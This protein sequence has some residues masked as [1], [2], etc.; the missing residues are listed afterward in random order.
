MP[1]GTQT[2]DYDA[3][4]QQARGS[5][6]APPIDYDALADSARKATIAPPPPPKPGFIERLGQ[7]TGIPT[8]K[9]EVEAQGKD[10]PGA[11]TEA[12]LGPAVPAARGI[13]DWAKRAAGNIGEG[14]QE[15]YE[16]ARNI[17]EG[18]PIGQNLG[19]AG[20]GIVH[21][22]V[23]SLPFIGEGIERAGQDV[24]NKNY[25]GAAGGLTGVV[26]QVALP[27]AIERGGRTISAVRSRVA[28]GGITPP[29]SIPPGLSTEAEANAQIPIARRGVSNI[30]RAASPAGSNVDFVERAYTAAPDLAEI[31]RRTPLKG[32]VDAQGNPIKGGIVRPD[33]RI[34]QFVD[35]G[36]SYL[37]DLWQKEREP[38]IERNR[39]APTATRDSL[40]YGMEPADIKALEK[41]IG[42]IPEEIDLS[43]ADDLLR[44]TNAY[45][46]RMEQ[47][48]AEQQYLAR[49]VSPVLDNMANLKNQ[50]HGAIGNV[51]LEKGEPGVL[52]FNRRYGATS[53]ILDELRK[54]MIPAE[55]E[56]LF[57]RLRIFGT[58]R[59][60]IGASE[61]LF[62]RP[63]AGA[64]L[65]RG[66]S[67]LKKSGI[68][69]PPSV[70]PPAPMPSVPG[71]AGT[72][73]P[74]GV[75]PPPV[76][77]APPPVTLP[78]AQ[79]EVV[80]SGL[81]TQ[82][83]V[84]PSGGVRINRVR[85]PPNP[86]S[87]AASTRLGTSGQGGVRVTPKGLLP[88]PPA[89]VPYQAQPIPAPPSA[90]GFAP[91]QPP[92]PGS[93]GWSAATPPVKQSPEARNL[94][95][96]PVATGSTETTPGGMITSA[97]PSGFVKQE[98]GKLGLADLV[99]PRQSTTLE[100]LMRGPRWKD[101]DRGERIAAVRDILSR[102]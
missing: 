38:Q 17:K 74:K 65:Q 51:L 44:K 23:G 37:D 99:T 6:S 91:T 54:G 28:S 73:P 100:T 62:V 1:N 42:P 21:G 95:G 20:A 39:M 70:E 52:D 102:K 3:L 40:T 15:E 66:L 60:R 83:T 97:P 41:K 67:Q 14:L 26:A 69:P 77:E 47:L 87:V 35:N 12:I 43:T 25:S 63:S 78:E 59:G 57:N 98:F 88:A 53:E 19:K 9:A 85:T 36:R 79:T 16:A 10:I 86:Q 58:L 71:V 5:T 27:E 22:G 50:L 13:Y 82:N 89:E 56:S 76:G 81:P 32:A 84:T 33:Y 45:L 90:P 4:A 80:G 46:R 2:I 72:I 18:G 61:G 8:S 24:L 55:A 75:A 93:T 11:V 92:T 94:W 96:R 34:R 64:K 48:P 29:P 49:E 68:K 31:E 101:M 30:T 7:A